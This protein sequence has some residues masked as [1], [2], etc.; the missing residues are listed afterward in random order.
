MKESVLI[1]KVPVA[2]GSLVGSSDG[3]R[4]TWLKH[5]GREKVALER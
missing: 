2:G 3:K 5:R 4:A 1:G